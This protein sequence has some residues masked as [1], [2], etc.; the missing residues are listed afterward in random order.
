MF[1]E[2]ANGDAGHRAIKGKVTPEVRVP[3]QK[4][5]GKDEAAQLL[6]AGSFGIC[7]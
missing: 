6:H 2:A 4:W 7:E 3:L 5:Y 1:S